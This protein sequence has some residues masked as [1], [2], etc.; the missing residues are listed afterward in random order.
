[1]YGLFHLESGTHYLM[2]LL[3]YHKGRVMGIRNDTVQ[4]K[5]KP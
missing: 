2:P 4:N 1:M 5:R 3:L